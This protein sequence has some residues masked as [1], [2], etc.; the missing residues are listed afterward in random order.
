ME[1]K[2]RRF[3]VLH[4]AFSFGCIIDKSYGIIQ[5]CQAA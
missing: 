1:G 2:Q 4:S 3:M 5:K